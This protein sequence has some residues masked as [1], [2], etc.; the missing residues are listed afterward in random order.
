MTWFM[1][2]AAGR[3]AALRRWL[4]ALTLCFGYRAERVFWRATARARA[5]A[6]IGAHPA[7]IAG[8]RLRLGF[9]RTLAANFNWPPF[10]R[11]IV[12]GCLV[13]RSDRAHQQESRSVC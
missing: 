12:L 2:P 7:W 1:A 6:R 4:T 5:R 3:A 9:G 11:R 10:L 13:G 8:E